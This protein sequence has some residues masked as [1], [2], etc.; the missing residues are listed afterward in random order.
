VQAAISKLPPELRLPLILSQYEERPQAEIANIL[1]CSV[2][3]VETRIY[4]A[5][6]LL[7]KDLESFL[8][9][10]SGIHG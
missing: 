2:K 4:R 3:A 5:K 6:Q 10:V 7:R 9:N 1:G 8:N